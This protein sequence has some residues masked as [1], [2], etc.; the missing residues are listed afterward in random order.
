LKQ[1]PNLPIIALS[2]TY[3]KEESIQQKMKEC[4]MKDFMMK[5][6]NPDELKMKLLKYSNQETLT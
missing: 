1:I 2:A 3:L 4:G 5:P 6:F